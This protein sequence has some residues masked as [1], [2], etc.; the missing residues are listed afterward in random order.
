MHVLIAV[1]IFLHL[2]S[3]NASYHCG[4]RKHDFAELVYHGYKV[5]DGQWP[6]H[7][8]IF[9]RQPNA[10]PSLQYACGGSLLSE[11][12]LLTAA[13]CVVNRNTK[14]PWPTN[15][16]E[17]HL[18]QQ[19]LSTVTDHVQI[20]DVRKLVVHPEYST[21]RNDIAMMVMRLPV[22]FTDFVIPACVD[23][24]ADRD[25]RDLE[26]Q[27]GWVAGWGTSEMR[28]VSDG[29]R[30]AS[31]PV[32]SYLNC[33]KN[34]A[35]LFGRLVSETVFCAGDLNGTS[36]GT[37][38]SGGGMFFNDG[39]R[40]VLRGIVSFAKVDE[41]KQEV[42][43]S[44]YAVFVN[45]QRYLTWI[46]EVM[47]EDAPDTG[48]GK[49]RISERECE[50]FKKLVK[51]R[52]NRICENARHP[53]TVFVTF[54]GNSTQFCSGTL[55]HERHVLSAC[56]STRFATPRMIQI[57]GYGEVNILDI[58]CHPQYNESSKTNDVAVFK[59]T[60]PVNMT[61][62]FIPACM[63]SSSTENLY[64]TLVQTAFIWYK[65]NETTGQAKFYES[66]ENHLVGERRCQLLADDT[67]ALCVNNTDPLRTET[68]GM[69]G[70]P[71]QSL[72]RRSCMSTIVGVMSYLVKHPDDPDGEPVVDGYMRVARYLD[73]IERVIWPEEF[74]EADDRSGIG[75]RS[76]T[77]LNKDFVFP[78]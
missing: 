20:R 18:G 15:F 61:S 53:H 17:I 2:T 51:K 5:E 24:K 60:E 11:K 73:W 6:W 62:N 56:S 49:Q 39:D 45:V 27:L 69:L 3:L 67:E 68:Y 13:H 35:G 31:F 55:V 9:H 28:D 26:G 57:E 71:L 75:M 76:S 42:D 77:D 50:R 22:T 59:L 58:T 47:A 25:L 46:K 23:Q 16:F 48:R 38:D 54:G 41:Q 65:V 33:T 1:L 63:A 36:P 12:H 7:G 21:H 37:G 30:M 52:R 78:D 64:D 8:A 34:D 4:I 10:S 74:L 14:L 72:N 70:S 32:V 43:T 29:L 66:D 44:K 19:N 40:W